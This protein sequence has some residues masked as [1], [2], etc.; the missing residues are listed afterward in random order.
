[1][2]DMR[3]ISAGNLFVFLL[4]VSLVAS[5]AVH[6]GS[7]AWQRVLWVL[8]SGLTV[9]WERIPVHDRCMMAS[10]STQPQFRFLE[11]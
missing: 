4:L 6:Y 2:S 10:R 5:D 8:E 7:I 11:F 1:M 3:E 9:L